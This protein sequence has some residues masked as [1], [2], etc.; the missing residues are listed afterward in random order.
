MQIPQEARA[1]ID[2]AIAKLVAT[3]AFDLEP[4]LRL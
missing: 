1:L 3:P 4:H 2:D